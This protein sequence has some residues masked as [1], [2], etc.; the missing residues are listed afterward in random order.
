MSES[1]AAVKPC[2]TQITSS[3]TEVN[4]REVRIRPSTFGHLS[5]KLQSEIAQNLGARHP[6]ID[7]FGPKA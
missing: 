6:D 1:P 5:L 7:I 3:V 4:D 2:I